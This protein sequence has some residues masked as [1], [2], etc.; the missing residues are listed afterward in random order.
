M[1]EQEEAAKK[2]LAD[3]RAA[4]EKAQGE[5]RER[6]A[7]AKP[8]PTQ[9]EADLAALGVHVT[10]HEDDGSGP[11]PNQPQTRQSEP[12]RPGSGGYQTRDTRPAG[13]P[14]RTQPTS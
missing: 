4:R 10:E 5:H 14:H 3:E 8:T 2:H 6:M 9:E 12:R 7:K 13:A 1:T 11:D